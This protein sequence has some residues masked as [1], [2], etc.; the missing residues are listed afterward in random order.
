MGD[1]AEFAAAAAAYLGLPFTAAVAE[2]FAAIARYADD[3][4]GF[5]LD[6]ALGSAPEFDPSNP[7]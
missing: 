6:L 1:S 4:A 2:Y 7:R 5:P 3:V